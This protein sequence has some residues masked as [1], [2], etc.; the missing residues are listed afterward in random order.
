MDCLYH[1]EP[2]FKCSFAHS[3]HKAQHKDSLRFYKGNP[4]ALCTRKKEA[5]FGMPRTEVAQSMLGFR[6]HGRRT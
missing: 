4:K 5:H 1:C 2:V 3:H 6:E